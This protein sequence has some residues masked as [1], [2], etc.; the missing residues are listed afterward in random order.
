MDK[1]WT[2]QHGQGDQEDDDNEQGTATEKW[3]C[4]NISIK[5][6]RGKRSYVCGEENN[7]SWYVRNSEVLLRKIGAKGTVKVDEAKDPK[8]V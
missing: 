1:E 2:P 4:K 5:E 3:Y 8:G 6:E 7:L